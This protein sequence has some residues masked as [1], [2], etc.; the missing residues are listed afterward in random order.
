LPGRNYKD[1]TDIE[2][3]VRFGNVE[4]FREGIYFDD[5]LS[6]SMSELAGRLEENARSGL[7]LKEALIKSIKETTK[8]VQ[9]MSLCKGKKSRDD[10]GI[11][12][13]SIL[14]KRRQERRVSFAKVPEAIFDERS[15]I[16]L[17]QLESESEEKYQSSSG[18]MSYEFLESSGSP[19]DTILD[20]D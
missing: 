15:T 4:T 1:G 7:T 2:E 9:R 14:G 13:D 8:G 12:K 19:S 11:S 16:I 5:V 17:G 3:S 6:T 10:A 20:E 18:K